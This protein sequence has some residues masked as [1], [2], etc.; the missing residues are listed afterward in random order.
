MGCADKDCCSSGTR[1]GAI[2]FPNTFDHDTPWKFYNHLIGGIP[3]D[4]LVTDCC[5]GTH[6]CYVEAECGM[7]VSFATSGGAKRNFTQNLSGLSLREVAELSKSWNFPE[8]SLG[9]AAL[10][11]WYSRPA[12]VDPLGATYDA[13]VEMPDGTIRKIDA[14][15]LYR[16]RLAGKRVTIVGHFPHVERI[17]EIADLTVLERNCTNALDT[18]DPACEYLIPSQDFVFMTGVTNINKTAPRLLDLAKNATVIMVGP[19]VIPSPFLFDWGVEMLAG[20]VVA[21]PEKTKVAVKLGAGQLFGEAL[22]M[23][24]IVKP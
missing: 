2:S 23:M 21:D 1:T 24:S 12:L 9:V 6:W 5:L 18:P 7:G 16:P 15:E 4:I 22:Q 17:G 19:S 10:N 8:A 20:S 13:P 3:E 14:F 11:A